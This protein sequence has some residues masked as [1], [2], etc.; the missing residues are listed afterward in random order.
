MTTIV[1]RA[2]KGEPLTWTEGDAN[3]TNLNTD[4]LEKTG[5]TATNVTLNSYSEGS[6]YDLGTTGGTIAPDALNGSVQKVV[7]NSAL[8]INA[9]T[10]PVV[11]QSVTLLIYGNTSY[12][13][14]T[15]TMLFAGGVKSLT[16]ASGC[17]DILTIYYAGSSVYFASLNK[18]FK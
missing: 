14:I 5:G 1:T 10:N 16:A 4:K 2:G 9:L 12:T 18:D 11:G 17:I 8:T 15:S 7:L 3:L 6:V 13:D